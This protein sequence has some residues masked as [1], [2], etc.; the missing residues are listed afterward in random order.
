MCHLGSFQY[1]V[2]IIHHLFLNDGNYWSG[3]T[4]KLVFLLL[5]LLSLECMLVFILNKF[6]YMNEFKHIHYTVVLLRALAFPAVLIVLGPR[7]NQMVPNINFQG[8]MNTF[9][10]G[11]VFINNSTCLVS[12]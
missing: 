6:P 10:L 9:I 11:T 4:V 3:E 7:Q 12:N 8:S 1:T 5:N 2:L